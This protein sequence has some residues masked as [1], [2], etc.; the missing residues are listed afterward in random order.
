MAFGIT[1]RQWA[2]IVV[3]MAGT[4][5]AALNQ[6]LVT[7][8]IPA[9]MKQM[10]VSAST[11]QW[12]TTGFTLVN[13]IMIPI[14][15]FLLEK[16]CL[17]RLFSASMGIFLIGSIVACLAP[18]FFILLVGR[19]VQAIGAGILQ[20]V[21]MV[22]LLRTFPLEKRGTA[23]GIFGL[24]V[25]FAPALGPTA[26]GMVIDH[27]GWRPIFWIIA[28]LSAIEIVIAFV[29]LPAEEKRT[30]CLKLDYLSVITSTLGFGGLL[31][32]LSELG[33]HG[34]HIP[35]VAATTVG[36]ISLIIFWKRQ[37]ALETPMLQLRV[38]ENKRFLI[39]C[40]VI[41]VVQGTLIAG[42]VLMPIFIQSDLG[43]TATKSGLVML[44]AA[45]IMG[46]MSPVS[47][48]LF[49]KHGP[50]I[51]SLIGMSLLTVATCC[52]V[53][54]D[55]STTFTFLVIVYTVRMFGLSLVN[56]PVNAWGM[57]A[58]PDELISHGTS[59]NNTLRQVAGSL[60][61]AIIVSTSSLVE[62]SSSNRDPIQASIHG[63]NCGFMV[64]VVLCLI[65]LALVI[66]KVR[67]TSAQKAN[68]DSRNENRT[69]VE[70]IM[71]RDV[72]TINSS[73]TVMEAVQMMLNK[74]VHSLL[75]TCESGDVKAIVSD[76]DILRYL[77]KNDDVVTDPIT[78]ITYMLNTTT[79]D[80][81]FSQRVKDLMGMKISAISSHSIVTADIHDDITEI[82]RILGSKHVK[83]IPV[84]DHGRIVGVIHRSDILR[85]S[86][87]RA[88]SPAISTPSI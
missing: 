5:I 19:L 51:L 18:S 45:I 67:S 71:K 37:Y 76:G 7:P 39:S 24:V 30:S 78:T 46:V 25:A 21:V 22:V 26:A 4:F 9:I 85:Y 41:M 83:K 68:D 60:G 27:L 88:I 53:F 50:R 75:L 79:G 86:L 61:T 32:G 15:A 48:R 35:G 14:T 44:P 1:R 3:L 16:Y 82:C 33:N 74:H 87:E 59:V 58:L 66:V 70:S 17:K 73:A 12:L 56:M 20:P 23:M 11:A 57:N 77:S 69:L 80:K 84:A 65:G 42:S 47:G 2:M 63:I 40:I 6:T 8:A 55:S 64:A 72:Y 43:L 54:L 38:L 28:A 52:F 13:A 10:H 29:L 81:E 49:D 36:I 62:K 34:I 31:Y